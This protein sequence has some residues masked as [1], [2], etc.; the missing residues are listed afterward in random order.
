ME[1]TTLWH[2][3]LISF[4]PGVSEII[5]QKVYSLYQ[6]LGEDCGG[7]EAGII[8]WKVEH[9]LD[10]RKNVHLVEIAVFEN[11]AA[12]QSFKTH[13]R[14]KELADIVSKAADWQVGNILMDQDSNPLS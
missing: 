2:V 10:L 1:Q 14:H 3:V 11:N 7:K 12:Y 6:T 5:K 8:F 4:K 9:N 13:P